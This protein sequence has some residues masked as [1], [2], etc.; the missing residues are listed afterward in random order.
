MQNHNVQNDFT[1]FTK[2]FHFSS[3]Q[4]KIRK[5]PIVKITTGYAI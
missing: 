3:N 1:L 5:M 2:Y 4:I